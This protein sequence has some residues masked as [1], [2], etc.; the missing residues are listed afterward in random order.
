MCGRGTSRP[1]VERTRRG[2]PQIAGVIN[3]A[4]P[5]RAAA[6]RAAQ[7]GQSASQS[8]LYAPFIMAL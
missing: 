6:R 2:S 4:A 8:L 3:R 7:R 5:Q 1:V